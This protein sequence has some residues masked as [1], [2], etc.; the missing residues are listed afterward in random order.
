MTQP[1]RP[2]IVV[3]C[4]S[5]RFKAE[6]EWINRA[7]TL[8]G[9]V[10][11]APGVFG[12]AD[13]VPLTDQAKAALD[14]LHLRKIDLADEVIVVN[15]GGY[16]GD[17]TRN[18]ILYARQMGKPVGYS[19]DYLATE[20]TEQTDSAV[21]SFPEHVRKLAAAVPILTPAQVEQERERFYARLAVREQS[22][23]AREFCDQLILG[24][25]SAHV[26][27]AIVERDR[28]GR[29]LQNILDLADAAD[30]AEENYL[31]TQQIYGALITDP[32]DDPRDPYVKTDGTGRWLRLSETG[33]SRAE[34]RAWLRGRRRN[35]SGRR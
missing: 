16:I 21:P 32:A 27:A 12:H 18:E 29:Q 34:R 30:A 1:A 9:H 25:T 10:V 22:A 4:G 35:G 5:T 24:S 23:A 20:P 3:L 11:L 14:Q 15:P 8:A 13:A 2:H 7:L 33:W 17:S 6:F 26:E 31:T 28:L 19:N